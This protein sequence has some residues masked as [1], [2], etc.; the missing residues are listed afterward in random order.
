MKKRYELQG[1]SCG[2]C[3]NSVKKALLQV[4]DVSNVEI[5]LRPPGAVITLNKPI[6]LEELQAELKKAGHY[7]IKEDISNAS[8]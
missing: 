2:G 3:V 4:P 1:M 5:Q 6:T 7:T 8:A